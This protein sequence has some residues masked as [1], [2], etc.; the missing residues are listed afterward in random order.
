METKSWVDMIDYALAH[1]LTFTIIK[2]ETVEDEHK[3]KEELMDAFNWAKTAEVVVKSRGVI[4]GSF[5]IEL[6]TNN[7]PLDVRGHKE[8]KE[9]WKNWKPR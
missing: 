3:T 6:N 7:A 5:T 8:F 1:N 2:G 9:G 4:F